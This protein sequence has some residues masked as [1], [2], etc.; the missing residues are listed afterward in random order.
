VAFRKRESASAAPVSPVIAFREGKE[1]R[2]AFAAPPFQPERPS[3]LVS[4]PNGFFRSLDTSAAAY[5]VP[6][7][8]S[9]FISRDLRRLDS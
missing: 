4:H 6:T 3:S 2:F 5:R 1:K 8:P 7:N 9:S